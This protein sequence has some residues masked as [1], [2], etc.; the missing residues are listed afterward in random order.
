M[1]TVY[2]LS[3]GITLTHLKATQF[4]TSVLSVSFTVSLSENNAF[5]AVLPY[6]LLRGTTKHPDML[7]IER[8]L[9]LLYGARIFPLVRKAGSNLSVGFIADIIDQRF[10][11]DDLTSKIISLISELFTMP[12][13]ENG[14]LLDDYVQSEKQNLVDRINRLKSDPRSYVVRR[15][16]EIMYENE[17]F[18]MCEFGTVQGVQA[19]TKENL[20]EYLNNLLQNSP[21]NVFYCGS[22]E[23]EHI[24]SA[25]EFAFPNKKCTVKP[26]Q[27]ILID[28][29][30]EPKHI[31]E[32]MPVS[33]GKLAMGFRSGICANDAQYPAL[34]LFSCM[35]GGYTGSRLFR[36]V[37]EKLSLCYYA[38]SSVDKF[39]GCLTVT[40][41]IENKNAELVEREVITQIDDMKNANITEQ[42]LLDAK[43]TILDSLKSMKDSPVVLESFLQDCIVNSI[44]LSLDKLYDSIQTI[45]LDDIVKVAKNLTLDT[46]Y[47]MKG[48]D[49]V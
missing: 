29:P 20:T 12:K 37:R 35:L 3:D 21:M 24:A 44:S 45:S 14:F 19:I 13:T 25:F 33:Q 22:V 28:A 46:V 31:T 16:R 6:V 4:K 34:M 26:A 36:H 1:Q 38:S 32:T 42:E 15:M 8:K 40:S 10:A 30:A 2:S 23:K 41:G 49:A 43:R 48:G 7:S 18:G 5:S 27:N 9:D 47:F 11:K 17:P 39:S